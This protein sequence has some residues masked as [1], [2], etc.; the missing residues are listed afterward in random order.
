MGF[1]AV[2]KSGLSVSFTDCKMI[3]S[4]DQIIEQANKKA[5]KIQNKRLIRSL[6]NIS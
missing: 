1:A 5:E 3:D 6:I 2:T 4:K